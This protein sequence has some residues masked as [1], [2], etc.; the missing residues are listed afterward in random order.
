MANKEAKARI[1]INA[2]LA[3]AGWRFF[4]EDSKPANVV[5]EQNVK[6]SRKQVDEM[7]EDFEKTVNGS[8]DFLL[9]DENGKPFIVL[10][11]KSEAKSPIVGK[12]QAREYAKSLYVKYVILSN[13]N[14][15][16]FWN[17]EKGNPQLITAFPSYESLKSS[18]AFSTDPSRLCNESVGH[19]Y[20]AITQMPRYESDPKYVNPETRSQF[21]LENGLRFLRI[22]QQRAIKALQENA[23]R[24]KTRYLFEMATGTGKT[25]VS[26]AVIKLFLRTGNAKRVLFLVDRL[27]L[28]NQAQK[29]FRDY[30][31]NDYNTV[32]L[33]DHKEDWRKA[34]IVVTTVQSLLFNSKYR[35]L[36]KPTDFDLVISDEAHRSISGNSRAVF[37]YFLG[38]KLGLTATPKDYIKNVDVTHLQSTDPRAWEKRQLLDTYETFGCESGEPTFR[39][40]LLDGVNDPDGPFL[41]N[42][43][44]VDA[45]TEITTKLLS[46]EGYAVV[47]KGIGSEDED[48]EVTFYGRD[49]EKKFFSENT[50][51]AFCKVFLENSLHDPISGEIGKSIVFCVSRKHASKIT[52]ILNEHASIMYPGKYNSDFALQV[53]SDI[54]NAQMYTVN[55]QNNNL[56]GHTSF[57]ENYRSSKTRVC[58]TVGMMTTGYDCTDLLNVVLMRP[59]FSPSDFVQIKGR[60]TRIYDFKYKKT[61]GGNEEIITKEK[62][63]FKLFDFFGN[64]EYFEEQFDYDEV[65]KL[66]QI[67]GKSSH[68][69]GE[70]GHSGNIEPFESRVPDSIKL[71][72]E[73]QIGLEGMKI[74]RKLYEK[75]EERVRNDEF[76]REQVEQGNYSVAENYI[77]Q[78]LFN[79]P[80]DY[81]DIEKLRRAI[82]LDR[83]INLREILDKI[84]GFI[85]GFKTKQQ[86]IEDEFEQFKQTKAFSPDKYYE[87]K[88]FFEVYLT[89]KQVRRIFEDRNPQL[90]ANCPT[91]SIGDL[92]ALGTDN[93]KMV[94]DYITDNVHLSRFTN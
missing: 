64:C 52:Q 14:L 40:S 58:V 48:E 11:A 33:K 19:D 12:E 17:I 36:F 16:Y 86:L 70:S 2:M 56:R 8:A 65:I 57:L 20:I 47:N 60:G 69:E 78:E 46:E 55:F 76:I 35:R 92:K 63:T 38:Y 71:L 27:E 87:V 28:E 23:K 90:L 89:D 13:G 81:I 61:S 22:Y 75:F 37:E 44:V 66:P 42:P 53:T 49:F 62:S 73:T 93:A 31:K 84:F 29:S 51:H 7:G 6:I 24:G 77:I 68:G 21:I 4:D 5:V 39:Y 83:R 67:N 32:I 74:D 79:K 82:D 9:L 25:L 26:A 72:T 54:P 15:H 94:I 1:K 18:K 3:E 45:R 34:D 30:L 50:N 88:I 10:E 41:V 85:P 59:I 80:D 43:T 91:F